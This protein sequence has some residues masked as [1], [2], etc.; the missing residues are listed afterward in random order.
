M[1]KLK[2]IANQG[3]S[4]SLEVGQEYEMIPDRKAEQRGRVRIVD[5][6]GESYL[7]P[8]GMFVAAEPEVSPV[9]S[10]RTMGA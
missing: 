7:F 3:Y 2:C 8:L 10:K 4:F 1:T 5:E 6:S 9:P